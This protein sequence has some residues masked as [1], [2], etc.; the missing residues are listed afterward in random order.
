MSKR[1][2]EIGSNGKHLSAYRGF[3]KVSEKG[4][5]RAR[6]ALDDICSIIVSG[7]GVTYSNELVVRLSERNIWLVACG[8]NYLPAAWLWPA[9]SHSVEAQRLDLQMSLSKPQKKQIWADIVRCKIKGQIEVL[10]AL[11]R[12]NTRL[13]RLLKK[14]RSG[15]EGNCE[16]LAAAVYWKTLFGNDF[17]RDRS[18]DGVNAALNYGYTVLRSCVCRAITGAGLHPNIPLHHQNKYSSF[19]LADD[20]MEVFRP[21]V[22]VIVHQAN[23]DSGLTELTPAIKADLAAVVEAKVQISNEG[24]TL[25]DAAN[26]VMHS[27]LGLC[28][29]DR[30]NIAL[31]ESLALNGVSI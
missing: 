5:E 4:D 25:S 28:I 29:G 16:A 3:L 13:P 20:I 15:D 11:G 2:I 21:M 19:R 18:L 23:Q 26:T 6:V 7:H 30:K 22:D 10:E 27:Y 17:R 24:Q 1:V 8:N 12:A 9:D 14:V 31:P